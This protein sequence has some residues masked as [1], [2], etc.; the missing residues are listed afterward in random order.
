[1]SKKTLEV[2]FI[3]L[4]LGQRENLLPLVNDSFPE[5]GLERKDC[6]EMSWINSTLFWADYSV[7]T[8]ISVLLNRPKAP[9][10]LFKSRSDYVKEPI[11]KAALETLLQKILTIERL[12]MQWNPYGGRMSEISESETP[13]P[14]RAGNLFKI[15]YY[16]LW[17]NET[18]TEKYL[19][20]SRKFREAMTPFVSKDPREAFQ[21][22]RD[23]D[24][25]TTEGN[26]NETEI[27][28]ASVYGI[29]YFK[30]N[31]YRLVRV[32]TKFDPQ[33]FFR[34][35]QSIPPLPKQNWN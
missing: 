21:N 10:N 20:L 25:G 32:K 28:A 16:T 12:Q 2:A 35:E 19:D 18:D 8:P 3:G 11:P 29:S 34:H 27:Q 5:L 31:F 6:I 33:N 17:V 15:Q 26:Q 30:N 9:E 14:H 7:G 13:F 1:M 23:L 24:I 4:Y 22:Y